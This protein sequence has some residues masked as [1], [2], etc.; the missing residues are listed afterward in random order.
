VVSFQKPGDPAELA[1]DLCNTWDTLEEDPELLRDVA[2]L[3]RFLERHGLETESARVGER[4]LER[5][6]AL[7]DGLRAAFEAGDDEAA[8]EVLN[9]IAVDAGATPRLERAGGGWRFRYA[10]AS[11][12]PGDALAAAT[13]VTLLEVV[14]ADGWER[15]GICAGSPC[16]CVY[17]DRSKNRSRRF[18]SELCADRVAQAAYRRRRAT[19]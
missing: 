9:G 1:V 10:P 12:S 17:V 5:V 2:A 7:R 13:A 14:R 3:R 19:G 4:D 18:C 15:F 11:A 16:C 8:V 6:R